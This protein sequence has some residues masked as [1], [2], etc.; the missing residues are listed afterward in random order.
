MIKFD[1]LKNVNRKQFFKLLSGVLML[2]L[3]YFWMDSTRQSE[4][5]Q[6]GNTLR[7]RKDLENGVHFMGPVIVIKK[8]KND[9]RILSS[10]CTHL[11]CR[12][13]QV[14]G[15]KLICACHGST[16]NLKGEPTN[17]PATKPLKEL[18]YSTSE[19]SNNLLIKVF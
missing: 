18:E 19:E 3:A 7:V 6:R 2:P 4:R 14:E 9:I 8:G 12:I 10:N 17:G 16:F 11:G 13:K 5:S 1:D 15:D